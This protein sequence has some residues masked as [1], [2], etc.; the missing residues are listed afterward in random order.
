MKKQFSL[1]GLLAMCLLLSFSAC[2]D[3]EDT[4]P[5]LEE[6]QKL[7]EE[8]AAQIEA[9]LKADGLSYEK[10]QFGIY[11]VAITENEE[12]EALQQGEVA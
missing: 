11:Q 7:R 6:L 8:Q 3:D 9:R 10:D 5:S 1:F 2:K 4:G 12:G